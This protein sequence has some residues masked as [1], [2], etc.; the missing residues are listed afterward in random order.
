M[1]ACAEV[2]AVRVFPPAVIDRDGLHKSQP[3]RP[4][5]G[6]LGL[7]AGGRL[8]RRRVQARADRAAAP[9]GR[10]RRHE[11]RRD[12]GR[13]DRRQGD[14]RPLHAH[15]R[16]AL[17]RLRVRLARRLHHAVAHRSRARARALRDPPPLVA[18]PRR[19]L[20]RQP[21]NASERRAARWYRLR[22]YR[23]LATNCW[24]AGHELDVVAR[25]GRMVVFCEVKSKSGE[26]LRRPARDG[27]RPR[28]SA[29]IRRAAEAWLATQPGARR[30]RRALRRGRGARPGGSSAWAARSRRRRP[31][32]GEL[33][34]VGSTQ[35]QIYAGLDLELSWSERELPERVRTKHV[36][37]LH[38]YLGKYV[39]QLVEELFR[40]H[41][42]A[43]GRV[44][45]PFAGSGTTL[46]QALES[47]LDAVGVD[48]AAFNC[49][50]MRVKTAA[51]NPFA[52]EHDL[53]DALARFE[54]GEGERE[55]RDPVRARWFAPRRAPTLLRFRSLAAE[56]EHADVLRV[57]LDARRALGAA[58]DPLRPRLPADAA[59]RAVLVPQ[60]PPRVPSGRACRALPPPLH[61][62]HADA[63]EG[64]RARAR[65][66]ARRPSCTATRAS[67]T[68]RGRSTRSSRRRRIRA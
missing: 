18:C 47:G 25:R 44:L 55:R 66:Q 2:V 7:P 5:R 53:R 67:S 51:H 49:L 58:D 38:P 35:E 60:A 6:A 63:A 29:R 19:A 20:P 9:C 54:R 13:L 24:L 14:A 16:R 4:A 11:E 42:P 32:D 41:V 61:A 48:I 8:P 33:C 57:V 65:A 12:R 1:L 26:R 56:Y 30:P 23:V 22:G 39:P 45:D 62:R 10:R 31:A 43:G 15:R 40:R 59:A 68:C 50:L 37:R 52:L 17:S 46:V 27:R 3:A 64:V 21:R 34:L 28:R 36:H